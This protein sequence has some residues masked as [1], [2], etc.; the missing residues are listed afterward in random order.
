MSQGGDYTA[1]KIEDHVAQMAH[2]VFD[3]VAKNPEEEHITSNV[4]NPSVHKH[5]SE[6]RQI[7]RNR[8]WFKA[9]NQHPLSGHRL[10]QHPCGSHYIMPRDDFQGNG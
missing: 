2:A 10:Y 6:K 1:K 9:R 5:G 8:S 3:I 7:N 4:R